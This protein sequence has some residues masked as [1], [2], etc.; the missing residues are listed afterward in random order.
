MTATLTLLTAALWL[1]LVV[2]FRMAIGWRLPRSCP[3]LIPLDA[4]GPHGTRPLPI[5]VAT[6]RERLAL[7]EKCPKWWIDRNKLVA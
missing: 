7:E 6:L 3:R 1:G 4:Q 2:T 5:G